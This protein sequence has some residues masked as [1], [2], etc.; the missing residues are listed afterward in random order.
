MGGCFLRKCI[1]DTLA[2]KKAMCYNNSVN[3][4]CASVMPE[5]ISIDG[6]RYGASERKV[7]KKVI[8]NKETRS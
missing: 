2:N 3:I 1:T 4:K 8:I 6:M 5:N 7:F